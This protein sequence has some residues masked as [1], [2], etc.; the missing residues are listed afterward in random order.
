[1]HAGG[2]AG[3]RRVRI[4]GVI[5][6]QYRGRQRR[7]SGVAEGQSKPADSGRP[8]THTQYPAGAD[9]VAGNAGHLAPVARVPRRHPENVPFHL[10]THQLSHVLHVR[11]PG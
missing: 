4:A 9:G 2:V 3:L 6:L 1:M 5:R 7:R 10:S 8:Q 11:L